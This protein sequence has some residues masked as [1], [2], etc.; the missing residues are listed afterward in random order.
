MSAAH[1]PELRRARRAARWVALVFPLALTTIATVL[2][3]VWLPR[4]PDPAATHWSGIGGPDGFGPPWTFPALSAGVGLGLTLLLWFAAAGSS[5]VR[6]S[7]IPTWSGFNRLVAA[8]SAGTVTMLQFLAVISAAIQ[9]DLADARLAPPLGWA[10]LI[11]LALLPI[12]GAIAWAVQPAVTV[13]GG[14]AFPGDGLELSAA[15][16][17]VWYRTTRGSG[18]FFVVLIG[19][20][21]CVLGGGI[22]LLGDQLAEGWI[23][24]GV[25]ALLWCAIPM[26]GM[27]RVR[28]DG[29]GIAVSSAVGW[30]AFRVPLADVAQAVAAPISPLGDFGG[31]GVRWAPGRMG[32]V[33]R[34]GE[35]IVVTRRDGR[36]FAVTVD[37]A[38]TAA[39]LLTGLQTRARGHD[40][41]P[42]G[43]A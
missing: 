3:F 30:P 6:G 35:G 23:L 5:S 10:G 17:A 40:P 1:H 39:A 15:E 41:E 18:T 42:G 31:W 34:A 9:L 4:L 33:L 25:G 2:T 14:E 28:V 27:F 38:D 36:L 13:G 11:G 37:D 21:A 20:A 12:V 8:L 16:R 19:A 29:S 26:T 32:V 7:G 43:S 22:W 24:V